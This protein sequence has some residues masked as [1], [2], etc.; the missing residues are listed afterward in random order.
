MSSEHR[1]IPNNASALVLMVALGA[2]PAGA[3][4]PKAQPARPAT[5]VAA[6]S[7][8]RPAQ[9]APP[10]GAK[11]VT[12]L[13]ALSPEK[14]KDPAA[15]EAAASVA[16]GRKATLDSIFQVL[17]QYQKVVVKEAR[18]DAKATQ[19]TAAVSLNATATKLSQQNAAIDQGMRESAEKAEIAMNAA[20][21]GLVIGIAQGLIQIG[22]AVAGQGSGAQGSDLAAVAVASRAVESTL[23]PAAIETIRSRLDVVLKQA[24]KA[25]EAKSPVTVAIASVFVN[26]PLVA[27]Q[28]RGKVL[29]E[30][31][32]LAY[33][34]ALDDLKAA[35]ETG[36]A[37]T[38]GSAYDVA[39]RRA[40]ALL[41]LIVILAR[42]LR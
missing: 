17:W 6:A 8:A 42:R 33:L 32:Y 11:L 25:Q 23:P 35:I 31:A 41:D 7:S 38:A 24:V 22:S 13:S 10:E 15:V 20:I 12:A 37:R 27:S 21:V 14:A 18:Q 39:L 16:L 30:A 26:D 3:Q 5:P 9:V 40:R 34:D 1:N 28:D 2:S 36:Q 19:G 29:L 4:A